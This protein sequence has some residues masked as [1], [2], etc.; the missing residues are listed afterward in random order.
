[1][2][3]AD[4][5]LGNGSMHYRQSAFLAITFSNLDDPR[6]RRGNAADQEQLLPK[7]KSCMF[8]LGGQSCEVTGYPNLSAKD[9]HQATH[10]FHRER[11][12]DN[13]TE[14]TQEAADLE[15][16]LKAAVWYTVGKI[17]NQEA[18]PEFIASLAE[19]VYK[20]IGTFRV[21]LA[22]LL[23]HRCLGGR[24]LCLVMWVVL[25]YSPPIV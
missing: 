23:Y 21:P 20:Q 22:F 7:L 6:D 18:N 5:S 10:L 25:T 12:M 17:C 14:E 15:Q 3:S 11:A 19:V 4:R 16:R 8:A 9:A 2:T 24:C 1:M 13:Y